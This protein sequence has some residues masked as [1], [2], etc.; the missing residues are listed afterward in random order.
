[1]APLDVELVLGA[2]AESGRLL[3]VDEDYQS[4]GLSG[5][6]A[7]TCLEAG[8]RPAYARVCTDGTIPYNR[9]LEYETLPNVPRIITAAQ[10]IMNG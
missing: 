2:V 1:M 3:V 4:Y 5:E 10:R 6:I 9:Q 8:L 7:A